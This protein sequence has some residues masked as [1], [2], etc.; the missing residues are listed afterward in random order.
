MLSARLIPRAALLRR[1]F[2]SSPLSFA[3]GLFPSLSKQQVSEFIT[4]ASYATS[5]LDKLTPAQAAQLPTVRSP[6][7]TPQIT[8]GFFSHGSS[9]IDTALAST[10]NQ[11]SQVYTAPL[12]LQA[13]ASKSATQPEQDL[14]L[15][16]ASS[17]DVESVPSTPVLN[18]ALKVTRNNIMVLLSW[19]EHHN[20]QG[21]ALPKGHVTAGTLGFK[22]AAQGGYEAG[23]QVA[24]ATFKRIEEENARVLEERNQL[25]KDSWRV[26]LEARRAELEAKYYELSD[27]QTE[28]EEKRQALEGLKKEVGLAYEEDVREKRQKDMERKALQ[29]R[30]KG[31]PPTTQ[32]IFKQSMQSEP[33]SVPSTASSSSA[34]LAGRSPRV[35]ALEDRQRRAEAELEGLSTK[36]SGNLLSYDTLAK[37]LQQH[38]STL[39][40]GGIPL[41]PYKT[42]N[43]G[44][45]RAG[46]FGLAGLHF[47]VFVTGFGQGREAFFKALTSPEGEGVRRLMTGVGDKSPVP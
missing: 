14:E 18:V 45:E 36:L 26:C 46:Y 11:T 37:T 47:K 22:N 5:D 20:L 9:F 12:N 29:D 4:P 17:P 32:E 16:T 3:D 35:I 7:P 19:L 38:E 34:S 31:T 15:T 23:H 13:F 1:P 40:S 24:I 25:S 21:L 44:P 2:S 42:A 41:A 27:R 39:A 30:A 28:V 8:D 43:A 6:K 33:T 10:A